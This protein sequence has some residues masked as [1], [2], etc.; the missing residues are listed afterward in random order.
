MVFL[1]LVSVLLQWPQLSNLPVWLCMCGCVCISFMA[2][3]LTFSLSFKLC[4]YSTVF[5]HCARSPTQDRSTV[6]FLLLGSFASLIFS[7]YRD[8]VCALFVSFQV[9]RTLN[10]SPVQSSIGKCIVRNAANRP[11]PIILFVLMTLSIDLSNRMEWN[12]TIDSCC[13]NHDFRWLLKCLRILCFQSIEFKICH[14]L[15]ATKK[16]SMQQ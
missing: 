13:V 2:W 8:F 5:G 12:S 15:L 6:K 4:F 16:R 10:F 1:S 3:S 7:Y 9:L 11:T 14:Y